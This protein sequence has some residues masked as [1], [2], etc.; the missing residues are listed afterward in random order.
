MRSAIDKPNDVGMFHL[1]AS[2]RSFAISASIQIRD[3]H[4]LGWRFPCITATMDMK[5][6]NTR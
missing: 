5:S 4:L 6:G 3:F 2:G 1:T